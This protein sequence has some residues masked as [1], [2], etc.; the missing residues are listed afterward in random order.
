M[1]VRISV[2]LLAGLLGGCQAAQAPTPTPSTGGAGSPGPTATTS[3]HLA[4]L[5]PTAA[6]SSGPPTHVDGTIS[7]SMT[8]NGRTTK[9]SIHLV[10]IADGGI[11]DYLVQPGSTYVDDFDLRLCDHAHGEGALKQFNT[12]NDPTPAVGYA[13]LVGG[14]G[15]DA[16]LYLT[17]NGDLQRCSGAAVPYS[18][19]P[20]CSS[21]QGTFDAGTGTYAFT[22][23]LRTGASGSLQ[24][25][26]TT[27]P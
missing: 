14:A 25:T 13:G 15:S 5:V 20:A 24:G 23:R 9:G 18:P 10:G 27:S 8:G 21:I 4:T 2:L 11:G 12:E 16:T 22:C 3:E 6:P 19:E 17:L 26:L 7:W 1:K